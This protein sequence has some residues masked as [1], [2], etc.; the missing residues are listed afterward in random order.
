MIEQTVVKETL[1]ES[2]KEVF[3]TMIFMDVNTSCELAQKAENRTLLSSITFKGTYHGCLAIGCDTCCA[4]AITKNML[5]IDTTEELSKEDVYDA[6]GEIVNMVMGCVKRRLQDN[7]GDVQVSI[8]SVIRGDHLQSN[9]GLGATKTSIKVSIDDQ[10]S[11]ILSLLYRR[12][13]TR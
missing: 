10:Y 2:A 7:F 8:P 11:A 6:L 13:L 5:G 3:E 4:Q 1:L 9:L 12:N